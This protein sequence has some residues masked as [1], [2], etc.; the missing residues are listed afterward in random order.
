VG[1]GAISGLT[2]GQVTFA[3]SGTTIGDDSNLFWDNTN[4]NLG[5]GTTPDTDARIHI[6]KTG[7]NSLLKI[8]GGFSSDIA[9][10]EAKN[11]AGGL[12]QMGKWGI[13]TGAFGSILAGDGY[14]YSYEP[15]A[16]TSVT[17]IKFGSGTSV[18]ERMRLNDT[19]QLLIGG[20]TATNSSVL[21]DLQSTT[22]AFKLG[23]ATRASITTGANG[24]LTVDTN[25]PYFHNGTSWTSLLGITN[26]AANNELMMSNG[27]NA[28]PSGVFRGASLGD[29]SM[30]NSLSGT[31]RIVQA[32]G[33][34]SDV[35]LNLSSKGSFG[36][37]FLSS[38][39]GTIYYS[40]NDFTF[41]TASAIV[42]SSGSLTIKSDRTGSNSAPLTL[43]T[44]TS[45]TNGSSNISI[46][47]GNSGSSGNIGNISLTTGTPTSGSEGSINIQTR[48]TGKLGFFNITPVVKQSAVSTSQGIADVLTAYGLLPTSTISSGGTYYAPSTL[49][50]NATDANFTAT[51]NGV[52]NILDGVASANR[53]ITIPTGANGDVMKFYNTED[54]RVWSFTGAT[55]YLA[56]RVTVV[57]ELLYN[58]PCHMERIDGRWI[59]TN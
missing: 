46:A 33:S 32:E 56:D 23:E 38:G 50:A 58:V 37:V 15:F 5:V 19:G 54:T 35:D 52:H 18:P 10:F 27:T 47:T 1:G 36:G 57:T 53:V 12:F 51:V 28:V 2:S 17:A 22:R 39:G 24:M 4:K 7:S 20:S 9:A 59:I 31:S 26:S 6:K 13:T 25:V 3:T 8:E 55:V 40:L 41:Q 49:V 14:L 42:S 16:I 48:A 43:S 30:G 11:S 44:G 34:L 29:L 21:L 45:T